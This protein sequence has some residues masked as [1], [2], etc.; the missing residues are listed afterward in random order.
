MTRNAHRSALAL[1]SLALAAAL[2]GLSWAKDAP[3]DDRASTV[4]AVLNCRPLAEP[5]ERLRCYDAAAGRLGEAE[6][7]GDIVVIDR[8]Q[9]AAAHR[10]AFGLTLPSLDFMVRAM[11]PEEAD[12]I[13]GVVSGAR[14]DAGGKW[15]LSLEDG[16]IWRQ[17]DGD[18]G[19]PPRPGS[20][21]TIRKAAVGSF[22]MNVDGQPAIRVHRDQ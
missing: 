15:T 11:K 10:Q 17:I 3:A 18:L 2:P 5:T 9:A 6:T 19:R 8:A 13:T 4:Q 7:R 14:A 22:K 1:V 12:S 16:A 21:V 20:K